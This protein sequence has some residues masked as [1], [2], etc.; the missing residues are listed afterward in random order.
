[1]SLS[2]LGLPG[3]RCGIIIANE[4]LITA[5]TNVNGIISLAPGGIGPAMALEMLKRDDLM[6]LSQEI[7]RSFI[8]NEYLKL[9]ILF[10]AIYLKSVALSINRKGY[11][12]VALV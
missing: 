2:K 3:A 5:I 11:F 12:L 9:L 6:R 7:I 10:V 4:E 8:I 1:M